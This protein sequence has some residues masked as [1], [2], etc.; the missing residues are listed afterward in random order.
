MPP[1]A[2]GFS[3]KPASRG[4][5]RK[6]SVARVNSTAIVAKSGTSCRTV[7]KVCRTGTIMTLMDI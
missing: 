7:G 6:V 5:S 3:G 1:G 2:T 4:K